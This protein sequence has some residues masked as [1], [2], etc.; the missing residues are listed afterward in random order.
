MFNNKKGKPSAFN[1]FAG[2]WRRF[3]KNPSAA[4][5]VAGERGELPQETSVGAAP[6]THHSLTVPKALPQMSGPVKPVSLAW[7]K[8]LEK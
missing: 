1:N 6:S 4:I 8:K 3:S 2:G 7:L 5:D